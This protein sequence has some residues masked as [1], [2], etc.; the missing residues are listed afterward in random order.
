[1]TRRTY[2]LSYPIRHGQIDNWDSMEKFWEQSLFKY[3]RA[4]PEDHHVLLVGGREVCGGGIS[5][6]YHRADRAAPQR[7]R[8][9]REHGRDHV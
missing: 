2:D 1:M 8:E 5:L 6:M 4:E 3:L 7:T 9:P